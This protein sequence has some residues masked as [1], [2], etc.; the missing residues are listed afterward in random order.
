MGKVRAHGPWPITCSSIN[1]TKCEKHLTSSTSVM[2][3]VH[4]V[5]NRKLRQSH[6]IASRKGPDIHKLFSEYRPVSALHSVSKQCLKPLLKPFTQP[7]TKRS[8]QNCWKCRHVLP[9]CIT[10]KSNFCNSTPSLNALQRNGRENNA[11]RIGYRNCTVSIQKT[12]TVRFI[13]RAGSRDQNTIIE[14][15]RELAYN[16]LYTVQ[17]LALRY[18]HTITPCGSS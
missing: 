2:V 1:Q 16:L 9:N 17:Y 18:A 7:T 13:S 6:S 3:R 14:T 11:D 4:F 10:Q 8:C 15:H 5:S 12:C